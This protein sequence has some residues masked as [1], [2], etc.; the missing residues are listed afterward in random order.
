MVKKVNFYFQMNVKI[1]KFRK[2]DVRQTSKAIIRAQKI[3]LSRFYSKKVID[4]FCYINNP[5]NLAK[6]TK[7]RQFYVAEIANKSN[8]KIKTKKIVGAVSV[9]KNEIRTFFVEPSY[10][11]QGIGKLLF[12]YCKTKISKEGYK[13]IKVNSSINAVPFYK[14][15]GFKNIKRVRIKNEKIEFDVFHMIQKL[16]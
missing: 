9:D 2:E 6:R 4:Y 10:Q 3:T 5:K 14:K 8:K 1:R 15:L 12:N 7:Q 13:S 11:N 16:K